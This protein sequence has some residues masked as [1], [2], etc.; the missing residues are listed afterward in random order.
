MTSSNPVSGVLKRVAVLAAL[1]AVLAVLA[2][3]TAPGAAAQE[4]PPEPAHLKFAIGQYD[5][6]DEDKAAE[7]RIE[8]VFGEDDKLLFFTPFVGFTAT[9]DGGT[10]GYA[11]I[12]IDVFFGRRL[13]MTPNFAAGIYGNGGGKDLG[14]PIEFRSGVEFAY[15]FD[16]YSRLGFSFTHI[17]NAGLDDRNPGEESLVVTYSIPFDSLFRD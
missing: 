2:A 16:D 4:R 7:A 5:L 6:F 14:Y 10:Y 8:Y 11:G 15:R 12:G 1:L 17:S 3:P 13:V 9:T